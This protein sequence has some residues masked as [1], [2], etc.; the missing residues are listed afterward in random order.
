MPRESNDATWVAADGLRW[1]DPKCGLLPQPVLD[2]QQRHVE[3]I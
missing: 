1:P 3:K 2:A